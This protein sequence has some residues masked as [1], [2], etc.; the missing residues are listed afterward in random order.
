MNA[1]S[2]ANEEQTKLW[3]ASQC[4]WVDAQQVLDRMLEPFESLL[5]EAVRAARPSRVLDVGCGTGAT[6]LAIARQL[7]AK[8]RCVGIDISEP[9]LALA[10]VRAE[11]EGSPASFIRADAQTHAFE[12]A[13]FDMIVSR[14]GVMFFD[15]PVQAFANL[16]HA[17]TD[18]AELRCI[19]W[20][21]AAENPFMTAA[22][23]AAAP[24]LPNIPARQENGPGQ[25]GFADQRRVQRIL[26][27]SG[28]AEIDIRPIDVPC[29][30]LKKELDG[31]VTRLGPVGRVLQEADEQT[32]TRVVDAIRAAF[33]PY[34]QGDEVR[35]SAACWIIGGR[36]SAMR[37]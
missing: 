5:V 19:A 26:E 8:G 9:M 17:A 18:D 29:V 22:E 15:D 35:F 7:G 24:Y 13:T 3:N 12:P 37:R 4:A 10:R 30:L 32:R 16:R 25:F 33:I 28:W 31:Y 1:T 36:A 34:V 11:R 21:S 23:R 14:F 27:E 20:R 6:T 2:H